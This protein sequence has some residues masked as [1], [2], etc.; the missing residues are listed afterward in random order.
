MLSANAPALA[1][2]EHDLM[3]PN[4]CVA[5][6][7]E[8]PCPVHFLH[9]THH[10]LDPITLVLSEITSDWRLFTLTDPHTEATTYSLSYLLAFPVLS[11][12][13]LILL[14][15]GKQNCTWHL[16]CQGFMKPTVEREKNPH[17]CFIPLIPLPV[18]PRISFSLWLMKASAIL[19]R[20]EAPLAQVADA[21]REWFLFI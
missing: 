2:S 9:I 11:H 15:K 3:S 13:Q 14:E 8:S 1:L 21:I 12:L 16:T 4:F 19:R 17:W 10:F 5:Q 20:T 7:N 18:T 6:Q